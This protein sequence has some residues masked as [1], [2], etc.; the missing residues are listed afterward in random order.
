MQEA[1]KT[2]KKILCDHKSPK[3]KMLR[4]RNCKNNT[5]VIALCAWA[6]GHSQLRCVPF[7]PQKMEVGGWWWIIPAVW[8][9]GIRVLARLGIQTPKQHA[10]RQKLDRIGIHMKQIRQKCRWTVSQ[11]L[12]R[13]AA[14]LDFVVGGWW[15]A[16]DF[17][18]AL[19]LKTLTRTCPCHYTVSD[20]CSL[21]GRRG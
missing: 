7:P 20:V 4:Q 6:A 14:I 1:V 16:S 15:G 18:W 13:K 21:S 17:R 8:Q 2:V 12:T 10:L 11:L 19:Q 9:V 3:V 5:E